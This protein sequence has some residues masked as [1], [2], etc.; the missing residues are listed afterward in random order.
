MMSGTSFN[1]NSKPDWIKIFSF[2]TNDN[3]IVLNKTF[4]LHI[5]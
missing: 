5:D 2:V 1:T 4:L 3:T